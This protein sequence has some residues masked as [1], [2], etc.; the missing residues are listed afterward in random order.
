MFTKMNTNV[1]AMTNSL[2]N[3]LLV[4]TFIEKGMFRYATSQAWTW[5]DLMLSSVRGFDWV[6]LDASLSYSPQA[7]QIASDTRFNQSGCFYFMHTLAFMG[8]S[9]NAGASAMGFNSAC[10]CFNCSP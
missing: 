8:S 7:H 3:L 1:V 10:S 6:C 9:A 4:V 2:K 5:V